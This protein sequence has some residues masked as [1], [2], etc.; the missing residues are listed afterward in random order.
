MIFP[1]KLSLL[2]FIILIIPTISSKAQIVFHELPGYKMNIADSSFFETNQYRKIIP[3]NGA[4]QVYKANDPDKKKITVNIP[5]VFE[6]NGELVFERNFSLSQFDLESHQLSLVFLG[7]NYSADISI[8]GKIIYT[9]TGG[10]YPFAF[11]L[12][13]DILHTDRDNILSVKV[14]YKLDSENTI[15]LKQRFL[16]PKDFGGIFRDVFIKSRPNISF[17]NFSTSD[18]VNPKTGKVNVSIL[19]EVSNQEFHTPTDTLSTINNLRVKSKVSSPDG[20]TNQSPADYLFSLRRNKKIH[21]NQNVELAYPVM[22]SPDM[23]RLY[24]L[25]LELWKDKTLIDV[26]ERKFAVYTLRTDKESLKLNGEDFTLSGVTYI[27]SN[28]SYGDLFSYND[29]EKDIKTI[30][31]LGFNSVR[32]AKSIPHPYYLYLCEKYGLLAFIEIPLNGLPEKLAVDPDFVLRSK[33][34]LSNFINAY[35]AY[36]IAGIGLGGSYLTDSDDQISYLKNI[37][38]FAKKRTNSLIYASFIGL[39]I[40][41]IENLD[42]YGTELLNKSVKSESEGLKLLQENLGK[43]KVFISEATYLVNSGNSD[44]YLNPGSFEAQ[45]KYYEDLLDYA[46][47]NKLSGFFINSMFDYRGEYASII[48]GYQSNNLYRIGIC[49][50]NRST[51]RLAYKVL[52]SKLHNNE[53]VTIPIGTRKDNAPISF[54]LFG[55]L[56]A[57][58]MGVLVNSGKKF[59]EDATRALLRP[60]N[61]FSDVRD[62]RIISSYQ[63]VMLAIIIAAVG[64]LITANLLSYIRQDVAIERIVLAFGSHSLIKYIS[65]FAWHPVASLLWLTLIFMAIIAFLTILIKAASFFVKTRV[66]LSSVFYS[67]VWAF[68]PLVLLIPVGIIL[69]RILNAEIAN[70]YIY[71]GIIVFK[72]WILYRLIKGI[73]VIFDVNAG[74]VYFYSILIILLILGG[75]LFYFQINDMVIYYVQTAIKQINLGA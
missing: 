11:D 33:N 75:L 15:P 7:V 34:Y 52:Y 14:K 42:F 25:R 72:V 61:F 4:W 27:P 18:S 20:L 17:I 63:S 49:D 50:E 57:V 12:P 67:V 16:F 71:W 59:R 43:G 23:P 73:Y 39:K 58:L 36:S 28:H 13:R 8:N 64:A 65:Y 22:W 32:F 70:I 29:M 30:K 40:P 41:E 2:I 10:E 38:E 9:H 56:L 21:I 62:Q 60:Y 44:G 45:A 74:S 66:Y 1:R 69:Y 26:V 53:K 48:A 37:S 46:N 19:A 5:S 31:E 24:T 3:L 47:S 51:D 54:I 35:S 55:L 6:G 68:I